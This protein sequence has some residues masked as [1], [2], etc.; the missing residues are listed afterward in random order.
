[1]ERTYT[2]GKLVAKR[3]DGGAVA[4]EITDQEGVSH[5]VVMDDGAWASLVLTMTAFDE[6]PNDWHPFMDHHHG[7][8]DMFEAAKTLQTV[9]NVVQ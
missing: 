1:M 5:G 4:I 3:L 7:Q 9:R 2:A 6:R 8:R